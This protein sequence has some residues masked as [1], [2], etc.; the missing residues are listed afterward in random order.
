M[1]RYQVLFVFYFLLECTK[2]Y[3]FAINVG[4][5]NVISQLC[6]PEMYLFLEKKPIHVL[7]LDVLRLNNQE[8]YCSK[9]VLYA[10]EEG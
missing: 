10:I 5:Y 8:Y 2:Q 9:N 3:D 4:T 7:F 1:Y 6:I